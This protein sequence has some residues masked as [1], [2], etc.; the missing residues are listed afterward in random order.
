MRFAKISGSIFVPTRV[1]L[2]D[3]ATFAGI[4]ALKAILLVLL[5]AIVEVIGLVLLVPFFSVIID[6][7][8]VGGWVQAVSAWLFALFSADT[9]LSRLSILVLLFMVLIV[10]RAVIITMRDVTIVQLEIGFTQHVRSRI[11]RR[12]AAAGWDTV[13]HLRH[14]RITHLLGVTI[15]EVIGAISTIW[16]DAVAIV[17]L[18]SQVVL[19]FV[20]APTLAILAFG[21]VTVAGVVTLLLTLR[22]AH[23]VGTFVT[24]AILALVDD[25]SQFLGALKLAISQNL[26]DNFI[27]EFEASLEKLRVQQIRFIRQQTITKLAVSSIVALVGI[28]SMIVGVFVLDISASVI[29]TL[30]LIVSRMS[31]PAIQLQLDAQNFAN[32]LP[33]YEKILELETDLTVT[34]TIAPA[35]QEPPIVFFD[36]PIIF[37][38][39]SFLHDK[40]GPQSSTGGVRHLNLVI[41]PGSI[42]GI[43]GPSGSG[44]T[45]FADLLVG[46]YSPQDGVIMIGDAPLRGPLVKAWR[47]SVSYVTQ[48]PFL[49]HDTIRR[50]FL[51]A[52]PAADEAALWNVLRMVGAEELVRSTV[53]GLDTVVGERGSLLS[54]GERQRIC[55]ARAMLRR[56]RLL[57]L[58]EGTSGIDIEGES[59]VLE[60]LLRQATPRPTIVMIAHRLESLRHCERVLVFEGGKVVSE[61]GNR[62]VPRP[63]FE[64]LAPSRAATTTSEV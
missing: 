32:I 61:A 52:N 39:V 27:R 44:K 64:R 12:L 6:S 25:T 7:K 40:G 10:A 45:T 3:F 21:A 41:E 34:E 55:L 4:K 17:M 18:A 37:D 48:D 38:Q 62:N 49:F 60:R 2:T 33:A 56:P 5:G 29:I 13:S 24:D 50:N 15:Q 23:R 31:G 46:L 53:Y 1:L 63:R 11:T 57:V 54:G 19:A 42:V 28:L 14:S 58:D 30:L 26:Q 36:D 35:R 16:R 20:L 9:R 8:N 59:I 22:P 47:N 43:S 51:W